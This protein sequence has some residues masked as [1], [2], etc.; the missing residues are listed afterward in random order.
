MTTFENIHS[1]RSIRSYTG[2]P[3][4]DEQLDALLMAAYAAPVGKAQFDT[5]HMTVI[6]NKEYLA[7][8]EKAMADELGVP[9]MHPFYGA[10]MLILVSSVIAEPPHDNVS[11][12]NAAIL[13]QNMSLA[14]V[15]LGL[16]SVHIWGAVRTLNKRPDLLEKLDLPENMVPCCALAVGPSDEKY[17]LRKTDRTKIKTAYFA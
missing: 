2:A 10:P 17:A 11:Y 5:L 16:G 12:S 15:E 3:V 7:D 6:T 4:T 14:A 9:E 1:R 8:L 13:V